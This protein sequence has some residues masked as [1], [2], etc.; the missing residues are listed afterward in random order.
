LFLQIFFSQTCW[1]FELLIEAG[2]IPG[3]NDR[4]S[5]PANAM[6]MTCRSKEHLFTFTTRRAVEVCTSCKCKKWQTKMMSHY[7]HINAESARIML[8]ARDP[9]EHANERSAGR[10][11]CREFS[12]FEK[13][14]PV[15]RPDADAAKRF[16]SD[17]SGNRSP[18]RMLLRGDEGYALLR[19]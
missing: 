2:S 16:R 10:S 7:A 5:H 12:N 18:I 9:D 13:N 4:Q 17:Q 15:R 19:I 14:A 6:P 3:A 1:Q 8:P 11:S